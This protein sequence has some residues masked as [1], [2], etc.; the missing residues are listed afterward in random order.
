M[1]LLINFGVELASIVFMFGDKL[2]QLFA[3]PMQG[4]ADLLLRVNTLMFC[5]SY[6]CINN[7][8]HFSPISIHKDKL[9]L[10]GKSIYKVIGMFFCADN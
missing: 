1:G 8:C 7:R 9:N 3:L 4:I 10:Q 2:R 6:G 5:H